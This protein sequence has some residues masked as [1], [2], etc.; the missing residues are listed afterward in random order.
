VLDATVTRLA[1]KSP[2]C[3]CFPQLGTPA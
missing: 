1:K 2:G 3:T